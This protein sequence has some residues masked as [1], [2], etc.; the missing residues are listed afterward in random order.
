VAAVSPPV[1]ASSK[2]MEI[3]VRKNLAGCGFGGAVHAENKVIGRSHHSQTFSNG[4]R[5]LGI[6]IL[7]AL[8][9]YPS[10]RPKK[11]DGVF[12]LILEPASG[13]H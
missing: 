13:Q 10:L 12:R 8:A 5:F 7:M 2:D 3:G 1:R 6:R 11:F 9:K 4:C